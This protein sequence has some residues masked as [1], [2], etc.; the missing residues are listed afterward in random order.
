MLHILRQ[1]RLELHL[2]P[3]HGMNE[4]QRRSVQRL[5]R[6]AVDLDCH[7]AQ[8]LFRNAPPPTIN[9]IADQ[10]VT[11]MGHVNPDLMCPPGFQPARHTR[12]NTGETFFNPE[13]GYGVTPS[14][15]KHGLP[16]PV[17]LV[18]C[19][20][21][22]NADGTARRDVNPFHPTQPRVDRIGNTV[23][24]RLIL[25]SD[26]VVGELRR[27][28]VMGLVGFRHHQQTGRILVDP[29][30][31]PRALLPTDPRQVASEMVQERIDQCA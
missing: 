18:P 1:R 12:E 26:G 29:V 16:L 20:L 8:Q 13:M 14:F 9:R 4:S 11:D 22:R 19:E 3:A 27:Q 6:K 7:R 15:E 23:A 24:E 17:R 25:P 2:F 5:T 30:H 21:R 31:D 10:R 28:A